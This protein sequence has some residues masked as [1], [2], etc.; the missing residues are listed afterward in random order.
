MCRDAQ[1]YA[2][3]C[4]TLG[5]CLSGAAGN[6]EEE[7]LCVYFAAVPLFKFMRKDPKLLPPIGGGSQIHLLSLLSHPC[8]C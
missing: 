7:A 3:S 5:F 8:H 6:R 1:S 2:L 4:A